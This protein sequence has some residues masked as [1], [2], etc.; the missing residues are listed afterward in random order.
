MRHRGLRQPHLVVALELHGRGE[1]RSLMS[2]GPAPSSARAG[3]GA[4]GLRTARIGRIGRSAVDR[5]SFARRAVLKLP[6]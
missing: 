5:E 1:S 4:G 2:R 3:R 6:L